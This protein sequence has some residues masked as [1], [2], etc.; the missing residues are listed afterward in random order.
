M[1]RPNLLHAARGRDV[2]WRDVSLLKHF[3]SE[4]GRVLPR[5]VT[6]L[7]AHQQRTLTRAVKQ[8]RVLSVPIG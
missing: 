8:A 5:R 1:K 7:N 6:G 3:V 2:T 4:T